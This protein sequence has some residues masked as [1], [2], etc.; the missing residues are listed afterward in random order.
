MYKTI[1][2][3]KYP[4]L[5][6]LI[7]QDTPEILQS[8]FKRFPSEKNTN[9]KDS[10]LSDLNDYYYIDRNYNLLPGRFVK[11]I[12][13]KD[14]YNIHIKYRGFVIDDDGYTISL[15]TNRNV[16]NVSKR[17]VLT[18]LQFTEKDKF[19]YSLKQM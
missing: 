11:L 7:G 3:K 14:S 8:I 18:L 9:N 5:D 1:K 17:V 4:K 15:K 19:I 6:T 10:I 2:V 13:I 16:L 12:D